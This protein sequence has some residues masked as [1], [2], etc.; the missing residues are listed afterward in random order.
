MDSGKDVYTK[1]NPR[2]MHL[3]LIF[4]A[5]FVFFVGAFGYR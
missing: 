3:G 4:A 2:A 1:D 5:L